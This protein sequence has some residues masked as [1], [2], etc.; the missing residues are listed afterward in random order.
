[1][2]NKKYYV[3]N[4][5]DKEEFRRCALGKKFKMPDYAGFAAYS[6]WMTDLSW[7]PNQKIAVIINKYDFFMNKNPKL[8]RLIMDS[9]EDDILPFWEKDVVQFMVGGKP[10][11]F[12]V[13]IVK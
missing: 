10:R 4:V 12:E 2:S 6:D 3:N 8:K 9:F 5:W 11:I 13:Y 1:M 7:I